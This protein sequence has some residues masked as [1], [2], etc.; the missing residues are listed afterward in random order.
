MLSRSLK[1][2]YFAPFPDRESGR[3]AS[4]DRFFSSFGNE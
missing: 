3:C 1:M 4:R 2:L